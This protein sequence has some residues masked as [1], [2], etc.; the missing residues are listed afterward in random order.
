MGEL[1]V[2]VVLVSLNSVSE[3]VCWGIEWLGSGG[4][5]GSRSVGGNGSRDDNRSGCGSCNDNR[6]R[7][8]DED[9]SW[10]TDEGKRSEEWS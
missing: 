3:F 5:D 9:W 6:G 7:G 2:S 1:G 8:A 10:S 4:I